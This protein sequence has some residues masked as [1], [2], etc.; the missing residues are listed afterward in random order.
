M[1][2][3]TKFSHVQILIYVFR[4]NIQNFST[5]I[6]YCP[7]FFALSRQPSTFE[8]I[9]VYVV[10]LAGDAPATYQLKADYSTVELQKHMALTVGLGPTNRVHHSANGFQDR[11]DTNFGLRQHNGTPNEIQTR[12]ARMKT[13]WLNRLPMGAWV[14]GQDLNLY[15]QS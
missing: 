1:A 15:I 7:Q 13:V 11:L 12:D 6:G 3:I 4:K 2:R 10:L 14:L 9:L 8:H 5:S